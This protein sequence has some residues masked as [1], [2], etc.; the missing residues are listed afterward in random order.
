MAAKLGG[1]HTEASRAQR[2]AALRALGL[3][4]HEQCA[5]YYARWVLRGLH[6]CINTSITAAVDNGRCLLQRVDRVPDGLGDRGVG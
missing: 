3:L 5:A 6:G 1:P 2:D 4:V